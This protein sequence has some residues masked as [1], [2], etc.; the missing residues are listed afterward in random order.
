MASPAENELFDGGM[1]DLAL[2]SIHTSIAI[3][4]C[5]ALGLLLLFTHLASPWFL[6]LLS[7]SQ[8]RAARSR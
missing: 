6:M 8:A 1:Q 4:L 2:R 3:V 5:R 7:A